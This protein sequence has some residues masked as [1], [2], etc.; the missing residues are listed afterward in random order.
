MQSR[1]KRVQWGMT[2]SWQFIPVTWR[3]SNQCSR[4][5]DEE[6]DAAQRLVAAFE[7][8]E[9]AGK[10]VFAYDGQMVDMPM[11]RAAK[12]T[13]ARARGGRSN[14]RKCDRVSVDNGR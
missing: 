9:A 10:G 8:H 13:L 6:V 4:P 11:V 7:S 5:T 12:A 1:G 14:D 3:R 2:A